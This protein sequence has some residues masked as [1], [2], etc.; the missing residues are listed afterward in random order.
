LFAAIERVLDAHPADTVE[1][2]ISL[3]ELGGEARRQIA[4][5]DEAREM[6]AGDELVVKQLVRVFLDNHERDVAELQAAAAD[7]DYE[8]LARSA[9]SIKGSVSLFAARRAVDAALRLEQLARARDA[10]APTQQA[11]RLIGEL[12]LLAQALQGELEP[13]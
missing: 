6:F 8:R 4:C 10:E 2:D 7:L 1:S 13:G 5:L 12:R 9:H 3:L 11:R